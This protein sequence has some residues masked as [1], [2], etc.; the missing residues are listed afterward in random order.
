MPRAMW[1]GVIGFG[2]V[3]IPI[4]LYAAT[5][6]KNI[7]FHQIHNA[8][9]TRI[10]EVRWCPSCGREIAWEEVE[11]GFEYSKGEYVAL[12]SEELE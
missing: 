11:K 3:S 2:M 12:S 10:K 5:E 9:K 4:R 8:C 6:N 1:S 7:S